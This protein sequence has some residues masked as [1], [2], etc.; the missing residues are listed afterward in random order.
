MNMQQIN[1]SIEI[2]APKEKV[3]DVLLQDGSYREWTSVFMPGSYYEGSWDE[4]SKILFKSPE[5][6]GMTS[7][8]HLHK[9]NEILTIEHLGILKNNEE[10]LD[11]PEVEKWRGA[12]ETYRVTEKDG[13]T[14]LNVD[15]DITDEYAEYFNK[16]WK[17]AL[18]KV[19]ELAEG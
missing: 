4:G 2:S 10:V 7:R 5:G 18:E 13:R 14:I 11:D 8:I 16:A 9:A 17:E 15:Q 12:K 3:W 19:K 6:D 1:L